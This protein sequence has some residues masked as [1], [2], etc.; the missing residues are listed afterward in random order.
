MGNYYTNCRV[1]AQGSVLADM[2]GGTSQSESPH[3]LFPL[4]LV[5]GKGK[6]KER[7]FAP[8]RHP[9]IPICH[10]NLV[11]MKRWTF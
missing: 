9:L 3:P 11:S 6:K 1:T 8:L 7:G 4:P 10:K 2:M 5:K